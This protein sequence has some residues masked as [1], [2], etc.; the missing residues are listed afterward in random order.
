MSYLVL[1]IAEHISLNYF[2]KARPGIID[3]IVVGEGNAFRQ[4]L[5]STGK[6]KKT[7][8]SVL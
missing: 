8:I 6:F 3:I 4:C 5:C 1:K 7:N 2:S